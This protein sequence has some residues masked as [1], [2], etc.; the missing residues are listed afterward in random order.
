MYQTF[1]EAIS[2]IASV[3]SIAT[4][5]L[6]LFINRKIS[7]AVDKTE[8]NNNIE[9][10]S[11]TMNGY[12]KIFEIRA[13]SLN[14]LELLNTLIDLQERYAK[15]YS[16]KTTRL[17]KE[18]CNLVKKTYNSQNRT[19]LSAKISALKANIEKDAKKTW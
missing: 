11:A 2:L 7:S 9:Q 8:L 14:N 4:F 19:E 1:S 18:T 10:I 3:L 13:E 6:A 15:A 5:F 17:F 12:I 16:K